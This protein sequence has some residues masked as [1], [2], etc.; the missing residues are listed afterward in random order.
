MR[1]DRLRK[2]ARADSFEPA[3]FPFGVDIDA[4][5]KDAVSSQEICA[6]PDYTFSPYDNRV[7]SLFCGLFDPS[8]NAP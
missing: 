8:H 3:E 5:I 4:M 1:I 7:T 6:T 2:P